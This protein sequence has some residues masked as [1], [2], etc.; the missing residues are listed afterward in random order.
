MY[1]P[2]WLEIVLQAAGSGN[3]VFSIVGRMNVETDVLGIW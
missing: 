2:E 1:L 3:P